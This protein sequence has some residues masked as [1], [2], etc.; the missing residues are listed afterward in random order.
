MSFKIYDVFNSFITGYCSLD[1]QGNS[2]KN[3]LL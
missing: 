3:K 1:S 2:G